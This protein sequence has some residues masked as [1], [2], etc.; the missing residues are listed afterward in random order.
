MGLAM[1]RG[2]SIARQRL[3][4]GLPEA[5]LEALRP[6]LRERAFQAGEVLFRAGDPPDFV[7]FIVG[8]AVDG[9]VEVVL[10]SL[11]GLHPLARILEGEAIGEMA[12]LDGEPRSAT[13]IA[14]EETHTLC[15]A[16]DDFARFLE[17]APVASTRLL[18]QLSSRLRRSDE[19]H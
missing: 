2:D 13:V 18:R 14:V 7:Y 1:I 5:E 17:S 8:G 3:L 4:R 12:A 10:E 9:A 19:R 15:V 6:L 11:N 16:A